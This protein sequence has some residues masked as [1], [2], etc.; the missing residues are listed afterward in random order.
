RHNRCNLRS[1]PPPMLGGLRIK[2]VRWG[3]VRQPFYT[4]AVANKRR[5]RNS[6]NRFEDVGW[7]DPNKGATVG[8][9][10]KHCRACDRCV[11]G[12]DHHCKWLNNCVGQKNYKSFFALVLFTLS[13]LVLQL[14]W[15]LWLFVIS[16]TQQDSMRDCVRQQYGNTVNYSGWQAMLALYAITV[17]AAVLLIVE[18]CSFHLVL[19]SRGMSTYDFIIAQRQARSGQADSLPSTASSLMGLA[20]RLLRCQPCL[21]DTKVAD[22]STA[23]KQL[24]VS[25]NPCTACHTEKLPGSIHSWQQKGLGTPV[26]GSL[27]GPSS[28]YSPASAPFHSL[29]TTSQHMLL[30]GPEKSCLPQTPP[31]S[32]ARL[33]LNTQTVLGLAGQISLKAAKGSPA[34][35]VFQPN[36]LLHSPN[37]GSEQA[38][39]HPD[40]VGSP[41]PPASK[42]FIVKLG[43]VPLPPPPP[44]SLHIP[45]T[46]PATLPGALMSPPRPA[47]AHA[48]LALHLSTDPA[49]QAQALPHISGANP[50]EASAAQGQAHRAL[51]ASS[52]PA[53]Q[54]LGSNPPPHALQ[55][56]AQQESDKRGSPPNPFLQCQ[57][58][59]PSSP[60]MQPGHTAPLPPQ[61]P[62][63]VIGQV[64]DLGSLGSP[65]RPSAQVPGHPGG[66]LAPPHHRG[67]PPLPSVPALPG[68]Q[69][70]PATAI[71][72]APS[73]S[74]SASLL[75]PGAAALGSAVSPARSTSRSSRMQQV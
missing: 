6:G 55:H 41:A 60:S 63:G 62:G 71:A 42:P 46:P 64:N 33:Q 35:P 4:I 50:P 36:A 7:W 45:G 44:A 43:A 16:F 57:R 19:I 68:L 9:T 15:A 40:S 22:E 18:L 67:L 75:G 13:L 2:L 25:L 21:P 27:I 72:G 5:A 26:K 54:G 34:Q 20:K 30:A 24:K 28:T 66:P 65:A 3:F 23:R 73:S 31:D 61:Q 10:S 48:P 38:G 52:P 32:T 8:E 59:A 74:V 1:R 47:S 53:A 70:S 56:A 51:H 12:F 69:G 17:I 58:P 14:A 37:P 29:T 49:P 11:E 39:R